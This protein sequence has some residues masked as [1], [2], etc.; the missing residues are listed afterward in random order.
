M[1]VPGMT[2][3]HNCLVFALLLLILSAGGFSLF[4]QFVADPVVV[5]ATRLHSLSI[6]NLRETF[7]LEKSQLERLP[8]I[9]MQ[10][11]NVSLGTDLEF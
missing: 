7:V 1:T 3:L 10:G 8:G 5:T 6:S 2:R 11:F 4:A 9:P